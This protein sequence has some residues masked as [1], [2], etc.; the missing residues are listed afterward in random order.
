MYYK[1]KRPLVGIVAITAVALAV[2]AI[3]L[4]FVCTARIP[5]GFTAIPVTFGKVADHTLEAGFHW[6]SPFTGIVKMDNRQQ[7]KGFATASFTSDIQQVDIQ[8]S[9]TFNINKTT[10]MTLYQEIGT[11]YYDT[12]VSPQLMERL[13]SVIAQYTA[14]KLIAN[15]DKLSVQVADT[16]RT[17]LTESGI[18]IITVNIEDIDFQDAFTNAVEEKQVAEQT[19][20]RVQTEESTRTA[21]SQ[22]EAERHK[23]AA[24]AEAEIERI[25]AESAKYAGEKEAEMNKKLA[26]TLT[27]ELAQYYMVQKWDG[28]LPVFQGSDVL[29][30]VDMSG[31]VTG[32]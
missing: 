15:R 17:A 5:T 25:K 23:I 27:P 19:K 6:K 18:N 30:I 10:A 1:E 4:I 28:K 9:V 24:N 31:L 20:L 14:E 32:H 21:Q 16:L 12:L 7:K 13:K 2:I 26:E 11:N 8:G 29:P 3:I 22:Q